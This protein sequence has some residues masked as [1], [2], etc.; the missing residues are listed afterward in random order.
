MNLL[1]LLAS[2][3]W[4]EAMRSELRV[5][6]VN[7]VQLGLVVISLWLLRR[8]KDPRFAALGGAVTALT[9]VFKPN[10]G[11]IVVLVWGAWLV[12]GE[13][14][15][16]A[17]G[18]V[19]MAGGTAL[20]VG[21][22]SAWFGGPGIWLE[23]AGNLL[24]LMYAEMPAESGNIA[25]SNAVASRLGPSE[26]V[27][28]MLAWCAAALLLFWWGRRS[29][30]GV[31]DSRERRTVEYATLLAVGCVIQ[32]TVSTVIW[33]HYYLL[34]MPMIIVALRPWSDP[35][36]RS[37]ASVIGFRLL[38]VI[39]FVLLLDSPL[40]GFF[41]VEYVR[42]LE[43]TTTTVITILLALGLFLLARPD[44]RLPGEPGGD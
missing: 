10:L 9:V 33:L 12:R 24:G 14:R 4:M 17:L 7:G 35:P 31:G 15:T 39:A 25:A 30:G 29:T 3:V 27:A 22:S 26:Q 8:D 41:D 40:S 6:N 21:L 13:W 44:P 1:L 16:L 36:S 34:L 32:M 20:A 5:A 19:G 11:P 37:W 23:W 2:L 18:T 42:Y 28:V 38:P 43:I